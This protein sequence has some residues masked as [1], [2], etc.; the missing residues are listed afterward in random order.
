MDYEPRCIALLDREG[1]L[2]HY[3]IAL[4][5]RVPRPA[6]AAATRRFAHEVIPDGASGFT[7]AHDAANAGLALVY[8]WANENELHQRVF[9]APIDD[10]A[11][12]EPADGTGMACVWELEVIDFERRAWLE[13]VLKAGDLRRY[14]ERALEEVEL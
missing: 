4:H 2:K 7:I 10:P 3:G 13:D 14:H 1:P 9:A 8:W 6:L 12:L 5:D 11:A